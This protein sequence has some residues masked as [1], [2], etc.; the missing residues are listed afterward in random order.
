MRRG[1]VI[2]HFALTVWGRSIAGKSFAA[3]LLVACLATLGPLGASAA[4]SDASLPGAPTGA[5]ASAGN[6]AAQVSWDAPASDGGAAI[7]RYVVMAS[8]GGAVSVVGGTARLT[9]VINL[10]TDG[11]QYTFSVVARNSAG[12]GPASSPSNPV[13]PVNGGGGPSD[14][15]AAAGNGSAIVYWPYGGRGR[16]IVTAEPSGITLTMPL[17]VRCPSTV[18]LEAC[19]TVTGLTN[20]VIY[21]FY[22]SFQTSPTELGTSAPSNTVDPPTPTLLQTQDAGF[23]ASDQSALILWNPPIGGETPAEYLVTA[24]PGEV[25]SVIGA[26]AEY[27]N[28]S[29]PVPWTVLVGLTNGTSY[30]VTISAKNGK[31]LGPPETLYDVTPEANS[32][33]PGAPSIGTATAASDRAEVTWTAPTTDGGWPIARYVVTASP[34][35]VT[36]TI[37]GASTSSVLVPGLT[38]GTTYTFVVTAENVKGIFGPSSSASNAVTPGSS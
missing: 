36:K 38:N 28:Y 2:P 34:G 29:V 32:G 3:A 14:V 25:T 26:S 9:V 27:G 7:T 21:K 20:G 23:K 16:V 8:P 10:A 35:G 22:V 15:E 33:A 1:Q 11:T 18:T 30:T 37:P 17:P 24:N 13:T 19:V 31:D 5:T 4:V 12:D 6:G